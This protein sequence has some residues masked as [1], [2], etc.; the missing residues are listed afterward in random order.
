MNR[1]LFS[2]L[3]SVRTSRKGSRSHARRRQARLSVEC[4][5][6]RQLMTASVAPQNLLIYYGY[7]SLINNAQN[8]IPQAAS[9]LGAYSE[10]V[11]GDTLELS[12]NADHTDTQEILANAAMKNTLVFGYVDLGVSTEDLSINQMETDISDWKSMGAKG[13]FLDDFGYDFD[14]TRARQN[15]IVAY[16]HSQ[17]L[18]VMANAFNAADAFGNQVSASNNPSGASTD[19]N[20]SDYY[21]YE[22]YQVDTS[23]YVSAA[24]WQT[25]ATQLAAYQAKIGFKVAAVTTPS[26]ANVF[27]QAEFNY[28]WYSALLA[29]YTA[30]GWGEY[31]YASD[32][33][34]VPSTVP[35]PSPAPAAVGT[36]YSGGIVQSGNV[37]TRNTNLGQIQ[38][39]ATSDTGSFTPLPAAPSF[40]AKAASP[41]QIDL[42]WSAASGATGYVVDELVSGSWTQIASLG[43]K[44]LSD[45]VSGLAS[46]TSYSFKVAATNVAGTVFAAPQTVETYTAAPRFRPRR[47]PR[48]KST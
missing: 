44:S 21:L 11:L 39:N 9:T 3:E 31:N 35:A 7:P 17:G 1:V 19:L 45:N 4:L 6:G 28:A 42:S 38:V 36:S 48:L 12:T 46:G 33:D 29:G 20:S 22:S 26:S 16:A 37:F 32:T 41:T 8:D 15:T 18:E 13:I 43:G 24:V 2:L 27:S 23:T 34:V 25:K 47:P 10:V 40:T 30:V 14:T 5:D